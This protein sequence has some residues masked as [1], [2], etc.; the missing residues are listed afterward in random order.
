[1]MEGPPM[2]Q[3]TAC[4]R[5]GQS[6]PVG[7]GFCPNCGNPM[8]ASPQSAP[9]QMAANA[10]TQLASMPPAAVGDQAPTQMVPPP[11]PPP[12]VGATPPYSP[13]GS[14]PPM[15]QGAPGGYPSGPNP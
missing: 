5:C 1:M 9:T 7:G 8:Q 10:P 11:P 6:V 13:Y 15:S 4:P 14:G 2:Q 3:T 12:P